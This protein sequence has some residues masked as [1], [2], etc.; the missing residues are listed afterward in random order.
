MTIE[1]LLVTSEVANFLHVSRRRVHAL[2]A[3]GRLPARRATPDEIAQLLKGG[4]INAVPSGGLLV[5]ERKDL[6]LVEN[7]RPG[8]PRGRPR[9]SADPED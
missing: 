6:A 1:A 4:R 3:A 9:H 2:I 8:Y 7:R 5:V